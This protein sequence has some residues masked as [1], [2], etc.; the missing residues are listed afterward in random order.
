MSERGFRLRLGL[1]VLLALVL[2]GTMV[3]L[4]GSL[5]AWLQSANLY[6]VRFTD[7]PGVSS[8]TP[9]RRSGVRIGTV[10]NVTLDDERG[11][12]RVQLAIDPRFTLR[13]NEQATLVTGLLGTDASIDFVPQPPEEGQ[14]SDRSP[15][16]PGAEV[17]GIRTA[18]VNTLLNRASEVVPTTQETLDE[19][20]KSLQ[21]L[22]R[23]APL[24]ED[25]LR[26]YRD[27]ARAFRE[28]VPDLRRTNTE[29]QEL[30]RSARQA[31]PELRRTIEDAGTF[32]RSWTKVGDRIDLFLQTNEDRIV[33]LVEDASKAMENANETFSRAS[34][35]LSD[36]N[37]KAVDEILR[38]V[39]IASGRL[40][41]MTRTMERLLEN[42]DKTVTRLNDTLTRTDA[43]LN[44]TLKITKPLGERADSMVRNLDSTLSSTQK[45]VAPLSER[46]E[47]I[48]RNLDAVLIDLRKLLAPFAERGDRV[49]RDVEQSMNN[50]NRTLSDLSALMRAID[51]SDGLLRRVLTDPSLYI[52]VDEA[53]C[54]LAHLAPRLDH[55]LKDFEIFAD[56]LARH[57]ESL[58]LGGV[59]RPSSG[60]KESPYPKPVIVPPPEP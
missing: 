30:T 35:M 51:Q 40:D 20:R 56:K 17:V 12:V 7:A 37:R 3:V 52:H 43:V 45:A 1:F 57:P 27:L 15:L 38:N 28:S 25:T 34:K 46:S 58:G 19:M 2:L 36:D 13:H 60:L 55:I 39:R 22:E 48:S 47:S 53:I 31:I 23:M 54:N 42:S 9:V 5:P 6:T 41:D 33:K 44:D 21:R 14:P 16:E 50:L 10:R 32:A 11:I 24:A 26:E 29:I 18:S 8:G 59:V 4:F 49:A